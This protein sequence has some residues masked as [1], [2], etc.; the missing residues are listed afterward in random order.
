MRGA[1]EK[2]IYI[3]AVDAIDSR[4]PMRL[5]LLHLIK[6]L[7]LKLMSECWLDARLELWPKLRRTLFKAIF[8]KLFF[9]F[10]WSMWKIE[11]IETQLI[12]IS[13]MD[14]SKF[15][16]NVK[17]YITLIQKVSSYMKISIGSRCVNWW[18]IYRLT[19][20]QWF[21]ERTFS[22]KL[23]CYCLTACNITNANTPMRKCPYGHWPFNCSAFMPRNGPDNARN[24]ATN[25]WQLDQ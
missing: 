25:T 14:L 19:R 10:K 12:L 5:F 23:F 7:L 24:W 4:I 13:W 2:V 18:L 9:R 1:L 8:F 3:I 17:K 16:D 20:I 11:T 6:Y 22:T 21:H 15:I